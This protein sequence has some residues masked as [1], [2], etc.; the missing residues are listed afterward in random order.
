MEISLV[1]LHVHIGALKVKN[2]WPELEPVRAFQQT[3]RCALLRT[4]PDGN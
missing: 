2:P 4:L 3:V 1:K